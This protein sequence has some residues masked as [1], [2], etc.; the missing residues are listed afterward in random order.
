MS[1]LILMSCLIGLLVIP[2]LA[3]REPGPKKGLKRTLVQMSI[4]Y[5]FYAFALIFLWGRC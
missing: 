3:A 1:K 5:G 2:A 4:F